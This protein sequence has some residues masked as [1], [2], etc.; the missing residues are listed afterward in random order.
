MCAASLSVPSRGRADD[1]VRPTVAVVR[2]A[3]VDQRHT[4]TM[5]VLDGGLSNALE[6]RGNDLSGGEWTAKILRQAPD[7]IVAAIRIPFQLADE[8]FAAYK[9]SKRFEDTAQTLA[10][11]LL[12]EVLGDL[13]QAWQRRLGPHPDRERV[14]WMISEALHQAFGTPASKVA[15]MKVD[16]VFKDV[17]YDMLTE[18]N[19]QEE[20][21]EHFPDLP[22]MDH[23]HAAREREKDPDDLI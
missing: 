19:F 21:A 17:T 3:D 16:V 13:P 18:S 8:R 11:E 10:K 6:D 2:R 7:E 5:H 12:D 14:R 22:V 4:G 1:P 20:V 15:R 23:Y 9:L